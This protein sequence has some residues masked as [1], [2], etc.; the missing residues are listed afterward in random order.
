MSEA[1][2]PSKDGKLFHSTV[3]SRR[4]PALATLTADDIEVMV[5]KTPASGGPERR[6]G[7]A[8]TQRSSGGDRLFDPDLVK[9]SAVASLSSPGRA[10]S[11]ASYDAPSTRPAL[12][13]MTKRQPPPQ[14]FVPCNPSKAKEDIS[15][16]KSSAGF[17]G[18]HNPYDS[19][20]RQL[21]DERVESTRR[22]VG[23]AFVPASAATAKSGIA[24]NYYLNSPDQ[25]TLAA[26]QHFIKE[27]AQRNIVEYH[28]RAIEARLRQKAVAAKRAQLQQQTA[29]DASL[30]RAMLA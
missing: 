11:E 29:Q 23:G 14:P 2:K 4:F 17:V 6:G 20:W 1:A 27:R 5:M 13:K 18:M 8:R 15:L 28:R 22:T 26:E 19:A 9:P 7:V 12:S 3:S 25:E 10:I 24:V 21:Q 16:Y 30:S